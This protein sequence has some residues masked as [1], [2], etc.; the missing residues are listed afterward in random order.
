M[1]RPLGDGSISFLLSE[2]RVAK[3]VQDSRVRHDSLDLDPFDQPDCQ[4]LVWADPGPEF[5]NW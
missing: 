3:P 4:W 5:L 2:M 1:L